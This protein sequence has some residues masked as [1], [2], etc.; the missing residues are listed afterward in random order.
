MIYMQK[1]SLLA[2]ILFVAMCSCNKDLKDNKGPFVTVVVNDSLP[3]DKRINS[4]VLLKVDPNIAT[5]Q[6]TATFKISPIGEF[7]TGTST[8]TATV[9]VNG[10]ARAYIRSDKPGTAFIDVT[11]GSYTK[12]TTV[13]FTNYF[14]PTDILSLQ[15]LSDSIAADNYSYA[16]IKASSSDSDMNIKQSITFTT[17]KGTFAD[18]NK[19]YTVQTGLD[20]TVKVYVKSAIA[21]VIRVMATVQSIYTEEVFIRF[22]PAYPDYVTVDVPGTIANSLSAK[23]NVKTQLMKITGTLS[24]G[25]PV[26]Y[27][28]KKASGGTIGS[29]FNTTLSN[30][31]GASSA[32]FW[33]QDTAY[34]GYIYIRAFVVNKNDTISG[35][36]QLLITK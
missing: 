3:A 28:A 7:S 31:G 10:E 6:K 25:L 32:D 21:D 22:M 17:D 11:V 36:S 23:V 18:G 14:S 19:T 12:Q 29:F 20:G 34:S 33:I 35:T 27:T 8:I 24:A 1:I 30:S 15:L 2:I 4:E 13:T 26:F 16:V 9:D 5:T